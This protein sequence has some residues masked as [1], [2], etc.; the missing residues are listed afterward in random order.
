MR[1]C[2]CR[3]CSEFTE[4]ETLVST[5]CVTIYGSPDPTSRSLWQSHPFAQRSASVDHRR[6]RRSPS[7]AILR[8]ACSADT[9]LSSIH[10]PCDPCVQGCQRMA[11]S[12]FFGPRIHQKEWRF[13]YPPKLTPTQ[14]TLIKN[15]IS[16][17]PICCL[18]SSVQA[19]YRCAVATNAQQL[20]AQGV[21]SGRRKTWPLDVSCGR[22]AACTRSVAVHVMADPVPRGH[23]AKGCK[24][25]KC[26]H[27]CSSMPLS[28]TL[29]SSK[30]GAPCMCASWGC[31][32]L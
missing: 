11:T 13:R 14:P 28:L 3:L 22:Q 2:R 19:L 9:D 23:L 7:A 31:H 26:Q 25:G 10:V 30:I 6:S 16:Y 1:R 27:R 29:P 15:D 18:W 20:K 17:Q 8:E 5:A 4:L 12:T 24:F 32:W 21:G